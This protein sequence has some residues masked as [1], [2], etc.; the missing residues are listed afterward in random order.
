MI[1]FVYILMKVYVCL[2]AEVKVSTFKNVITYCYILTPT[3]CKY[4]NF[5]ITI[6]L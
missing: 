5:M 2:H 3:L 1:L 6:T 4:M